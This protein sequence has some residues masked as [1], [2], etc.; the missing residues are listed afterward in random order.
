MSQGTKNPRAIA[1]N[2]YELGAVY[3]VTYCGSA[4]SDSLSPEAGINI[5]RASTTLARLRESGRMLCRLTVD[6]KMTLRPQH[7]PLGEWNVDTPPY[8]RQGRDLNTF[9]MCATS[10]ALSA[11]GGK[12]KSPRIGVLTRAQVI[13][14]TFLKRQRILPRPCRGAGMTQLVTGSAHAQTISAP[15]G[16][17]NPGC[18]FRGR[19]TTPNVI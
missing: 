2:D 19:G 4:V 16:A 9:H 13:I 10:G 12:T 17:Y 7:P 6:T 3:L 5:R 8:S 1:V 14:I 11:S 18:H 15:R